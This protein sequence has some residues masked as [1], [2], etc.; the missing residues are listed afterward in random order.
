MQAER[1]PLRVQ[2][3]PLIR[4]ASP[5]AVGAQQR[6]QQMALRE[7][8]PRPLAQHVGGAIRDHI[9]AAIYRVGD[10][11]ADPLEAAARDLDRVVYALAQVAGERQDLRPRPVDRR[12]RPQK[13][14]ARLAACPCSIVQTASPSTVAGGC[15]F[16]KSCPNGTTTAARAPCTCHTQ[17]G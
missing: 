6:H 7:A 16:G 9:V 4:Q 3:Q 13:R 17:E 5:E 2:R 11:V 8:E 10:A 12:R 1:L 14:I 15:P